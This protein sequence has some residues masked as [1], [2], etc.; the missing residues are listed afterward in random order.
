[1][2][3]SLSLFI[4][5]CLLFAVI[6]ACSKGS[7]GTDGTQLGGGVNYN[8][9]VDTTPPGIS[10]I[11]P[12][13]N[14][15]FTSGNTI[16]ISGTITD[17]YGMYR[18]SI[19]VYNDGTNTLLSQQLYEAHYLLSYNYSLNYTPV[20]ITPTILRIEVSFEDHGANVTTKSVKV[21]INP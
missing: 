12:T 15:V 13:D 17:D 3:N 10:I 4:S 14:Q 21:T 2:K 9:V 18:G 8:T 6:S 5:S 7:A 1:M 11:T 19:R 20:V 16:N